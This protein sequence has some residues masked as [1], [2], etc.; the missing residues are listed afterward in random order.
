MADKKEIEQAKRE[1]EIIAA[2][3]Q[4]KDPT[5]ATDGLPTSSGRPSTPQPYKRGPYREDVAE[6]RRAEKEERDKVVDRDAEEAEAQADPNT[7]PDSLGFDQQKIEGGDVREYEGHDRD[8]ATKEPA[9]NPVVEDNK[10]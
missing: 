1:A 3:K 4:A 5:A 7:P 6:A 8:P 9:G 2:V 10:E